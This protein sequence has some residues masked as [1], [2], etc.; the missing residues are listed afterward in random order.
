[1]IFVRIDQ[2]FAALSANHS[3]TIA[4]DL[5]L[6]HIPINAKRFSWPVVID[7]VYD[8]VCCFFACLA[9]KFSKLQLSCYS[10]L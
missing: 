9:N 8:E 7:V 2:S 6:E 10:I 3:S 1:M 5:N 4:Y